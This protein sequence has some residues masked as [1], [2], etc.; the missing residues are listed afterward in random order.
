MNHV[1]VDE[2]VRH[3]GTESARSWRRPG[4]RPSEPHEGQTP[5]VLE[6]GIDG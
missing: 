6:V 2:R 4:T 1:T 3:L 5:S